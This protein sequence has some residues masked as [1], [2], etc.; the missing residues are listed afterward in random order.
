MSDA[1]TSV[2]GVVPTATPFTSQ[3]KNTS[4]LV[5]II[6]A[7]VGGFVLIIALILVIV[8]LARRRASRRQP[9]Q[10]DN[11][12]VSGRTSPTVNS[13]RGV[14]NRAISADA[15]VPLLHPDPNASVEYSRFGSTTA[16]SDT[17]TQSS[18]PPTPSATS[19][20]LH[21]PRRFAPTFR[22]FST[23]SPSPDLEPGLPRSLRSS[24]P[25]PLRHARTRIARV[26][27]DPLP[28]DS[29]T[30][31]SPQRGQSPTTSSA[32]SHAPIP[33]PAP[34]LPASEPAPPPASARSSSPTPTPASWLHI[35]KA[36][37]IPLI[38]AFRG[39]ISSLASAASSLPTMQ[40]YPSFNQN[41]RS[42]SASTRSSQTFFSVTSDA[43]TTGHH[44][45]HL[46][47]PPQPPTTIPSEYGELLSPSG[48]SGPP[49]R[50]K[51][52]GAGERTPQV[53]Q[54]PSDDVHE[55]RQASMVYGHNNNSSMLSIPRILLPGEGGRPVS[56]TMGTG[57]SVSLYTD[58]RS[59]LG[60]V[61]EDGRLN[62][63]VGGGSS[64]GGKARGRQ[65]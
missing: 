62:G 17:A 65:S 2:T 13:H 51:P 48:L 44:H 22:S 37:G 26:P 46:P 3:S 64:G 19:S 60:G 43:P 41:A 4:K 40:H 63:S 27:M 47:T 30:D 7:T 8:P 23:R 55:S 6:V 38:G 42:A 58:A 52:G 54:S 35:P 31:V 57:S 29:V 32:E 25:Q 12:T 9:K 5:I 20:L 1:T 45:H 28:E 53:H 34:T 56:S 50:F 18:V 14:H 36:S 11:S 33:A 16:Q 15:F 49:V 39:S 61:G 21:S 10:A 59:Q 24:Q